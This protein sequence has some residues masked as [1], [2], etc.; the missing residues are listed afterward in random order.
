MTSQTF[1]ISVPIADRRRAM[2]FSGDGLGLTPVGP[3]AA[4]GIPEPLQ[5][6]LGPHCTLMLVPTGG[7]GWVVGDREVAPAGVS[8]CVL[9]M[10][11]ATEDEV[12]D[13]VDR[14]RRAGGTVLTEPAQLPWGYSSTW[15]DL[16]GHLWQVTVAPSAP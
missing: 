13:V 2:D 1:I 3:L 11:V 4:D 6:E 8:E 10:G 14:V 12:T 7:F 15:A 16:D 5:F 9:S